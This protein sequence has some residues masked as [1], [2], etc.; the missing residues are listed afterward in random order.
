MDEEDKT[1]TCRF[2]GEICD[3]DMATDHV[4]DGR[5]LH[6]RLVLAALQGAAW[7][8]HNPRQIVGDAYAIADAAYALRNE[9]HGEVK[10]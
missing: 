1:W 6:D 9:R 10:P 2:C 7:A 3:L 4:C 8:Q 5:E